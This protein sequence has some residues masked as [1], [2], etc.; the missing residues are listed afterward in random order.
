MQSEE[1]VTAWEAK[2]ALNDARGHCFDGQQG[3]PAMYH[4]GCK[5]NPATCALGATAP[6]AF[7]DPPETLGQIYRRCEKCGLN[8]YEWGTDQPAKTPNSWSKLVPSGQHKDC[9]QTGRDLVAIVS[10]RRDL[11]RFRDLHS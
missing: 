8:I 3:D 10:Q 2:C 7:V 1:K 5:P 4:Q 6:A 11:Q 9:P